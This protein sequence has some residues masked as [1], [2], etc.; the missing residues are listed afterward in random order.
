MCAGSVSGW[1]KLVLH[2]WELWTCSSACHFASYNIWVITI[3]TESWCLVSS[4]W[5]SSV[6]DCFWWRDDLY[7][8]QREQA[9]V[10]VITHA[11]LK[12]LIST[13]WR[14]TIIDITISTLCL[15]I[16]VLKT[17]YE[18]QTGERIRTCD[19]RQTFDSCHVYTT[20]NKPSEG[21]SRL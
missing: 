20:N 15:W 9:V 21:P 19:Q 1:F 17:S 8:L 6:L 4:V 2:M 7:F 14:L 18:V 11:V 13:W 12:E 16:T 10:S 3:P 5:Q